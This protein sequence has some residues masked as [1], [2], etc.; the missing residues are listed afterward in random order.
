MTLREATHSLYEHLGCGV[1]PNWV[2]S[3][4]EGD[5]TIHVYIVRKPRGRDNVPETWEGFPVKTIIVGEMRLCNEMPKSV[6][7]YEKLYKGSPIEE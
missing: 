5:N 4:G 3:I 7:E 1:Y 6:A 2:Q